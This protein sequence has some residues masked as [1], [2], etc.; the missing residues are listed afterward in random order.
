MEKYIIN[1]SLG[2]VRLPFNLTSD[3]DDSMKE[4]RKSEIVKN[5]LNQETEQI[6]DYEMTSFKSQYQTLTFD[7]FFHRRLNLT[8]N[9]DIRGMLGTYYTDYYD[10]MK[11]KFS[12][13]SD[14]P[15]SEYPSFWNSFGY[16]FYSKKETWYAANSDGTP[17]NSLLSKRFDTQ[18]YLYNSF[19]KMN[20]YTTPYASTQESLF[21]NILYVNPR[22]CELE[23]DENGSWH[24]PTFNLNEN[25]DGYYIY[26]LNKYN[27]DTFYV[28]FQFWDALNGRSIN[29]LP[30][31]PYEPNK[32]W[33]QS[34]VNGFD[35][36]MLYAEY[37]VNYS[38]KKY[39]IRIFDPISETWVV[40]PNKILLYELIFDNYFAELNPL[41]SVSNGVPKTT[42][43]IVTGTT[44]TDFDIQLSASSTDFN[45]NGD[46][47]VTPYIF[48]GYVDRNGFQELRSEW[49]SAAALSLEKYEDSIKI[50]NKS[51]VSTYLKNVEIKLL[52]DTGSDR[53]NRLT[54]QYK[55][56][57]YNVTNGSTLTNY[58][59][60]SVPDYNAE[61][62]RQFNFESYYYPDRNIGSYDPLYGKTV[63]VK[64]IDDN[65][66]TSWKSEAWMGWK[67]PLNNSNFTIWGQDLGEKLM[68]SHDGNDL[69]EI[70]SNGEMNVNITWGFGKYYGY[71]NVEPLFY[72]MCGNQNNFPSKNYTV[73]LDYE[74]TLYFNDLNNT[75]PEYSNK[76]TFT[77]KPYFQFQYI[78]KSGNSKP[79]G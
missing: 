46:S 21:Q 23:G 32:H 20:F 79:Q 74:V 67:Y 44:V 36:R 71:A 29:L 78:K 12:D 8:A 26:W 59:L 7:L 41:I 39:T 2:F 31:H 18:S 61:N 22:W 64:G 9:Q 70:P 42:T 5:A 47:G 33:V 69:Y 34:A 63:A 66:P 76:V 50:Y 38:N 30:S 37:K 24:R 62:G 40:K 14:T 48:N 6:N 3:N 35:S 77:V 16:P 27:I 4:I 55:S 56:V 45:L 60:S 49:N 73:N 17:S 43:A 19:I 15:V 57:K 25:T 28:S 65:E 10:Q 1:R 11:N 13:T 68:I 58:I 54:G 53:K 52:N 51:D 72:Q 75:L